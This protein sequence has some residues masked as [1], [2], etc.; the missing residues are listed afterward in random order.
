MKNC[1]Y[2]KIEV[3]GDFTYCPLCQNLLI[4]Q[5]DEKYWPSPKTLKKNT[6]I[7]KTLA[8]AIFSCIIAVFLFDLWSDPAH[9]AVDWSPIV[10]IWLFIGGITASSVVRT[11][12]EPPSIFTRIAIA[13]L[14]AL[15]L[16]TFWY[17]VL[18]DIIPIPVLGIL[19]VNFI[20]TLIDKGGNVMVYFLSCSLACI[21]SW[22]IV[23]ILLKHN[24]SILW[25]ICF[26]VS[27]ITFVGMLIFKGR[28]LVS[29][30]QKRFSI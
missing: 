2:C 1:P 28:S 21:L 25:R 27:C 4:G 5:P 12:K 18:F 20:A 17:P 6:K 9:P 11:H 7:Q 15:I 30:I 3:G 24:M 16:S 22:I 13:G 26:M 23:I 29:E 8:F 19:A 10:I 14:I